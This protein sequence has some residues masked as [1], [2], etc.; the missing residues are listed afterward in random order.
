METEHSFLGEALP[1]PFGSFR[2]ILTALFK[3]RWKC[4][5]AF[6]VVLGGMAI[7]VNTLIPLYEAKASI[8]IK[9][10]REHI[11][12]PEVGQI[13]QIVKFDE[14]AAVQSEISI[15]TSRELIR[16]VIET[17]GVEKVYPE[18]LDPSKGIR[19]PLEVGVSQ[20]VSDLT[21]TSVKGSN[22][23]EVTYGNPRPQVAAE[24]L[25]LLIEYLKEKHL[26]IFSDPR[27]SFLSNQLRV[28]QDQLETSERQLQEFNRKYDLS[29][30]IEDQQK[31]LLDQRT[32]MDT[33]YKLT[34]NQI[35]G[36]Q[37]R[38]QSIEAQMKTIPKEMAL[39]RTETEGTLAKAKA[40][41]FELRRKE[42]NLLTR[43]TDESFPVKNL[44]N[45]IALIEGF[46]QEE[47]KNN[48]RNNS[49]TS[50]KNPVYQKLEMD[51]F[52]AQ[53]ELETLE[54]SSKAISLQIEE[55][56]RKL[57]RLDELNKELLIL[58]RQK[59]A[60]GQNYNLYLHKVEEAKVSEEMDR[61]KM[62]NISVIQH[63]ERPTGK[64]GRSPNLLLMVGAIMGVLGGIGLGLILEFFEGAY[65]RP[66]QA[67][68]DLNLPLLASF[69]QKV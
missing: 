26:Q 25:N 34:K 8:V 63:A 32:Q 6:C 38:I 10:G 28:Y 14:E 45:E 61:L 22:V 27:A 55:L 9:M 66:E 30:P 46:I 64:A 50:G 2:D 37:S 35:Q 36:L 67:A 49:V 23:I 4:V 53:S 59:E 17:L 3:H 33:S 62:S 40:D 41:L 20:F 43:Y 52:G 11:F 51:W 47:E 21:P 13:N 19:N 44:R 56:D 42:Q 15:L 60:A 24:A 65:T 48:D 57:Q 1:Y 54:A 7:Y 29:S 39:S 12:R 68:S 5:I 69:S 18:L 58:S 31:R 16:R